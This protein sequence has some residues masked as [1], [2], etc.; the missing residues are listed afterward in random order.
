MLLHN[1]A[2]NQWYFDTDN[3]MPHT[4]IHTYGNRIPLQ[5]QNKHK[6][7][8]RQKSVSWS[9]IQGHAI[10]EHSLEIWT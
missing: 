2:S 8:D 7:T 5:K 6:K 4:L 3:L 10:L 9:Y 1:Y